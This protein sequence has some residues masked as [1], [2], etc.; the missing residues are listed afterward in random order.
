MASSSAAPMPA[1][2]HDFSPFFRVYEDG[3]VER[4]TIEE[5]IPASFDSCTG[6]T[7]KDISISADVPARL[8][9]PKIAAAASPNKLPL[10]V[11]FRGGG[12]CMMSLSTPILHN[13]LNAFAAASNVVLLHVNYRRAP[14]HR[15][16]VPYEDSWAAVEW[17]ASHRGGDGPEPW[18]ADHVDFDRVF[19]AG[20]SAG[21]NIAHNLA[22]R[23]AERELPGGVRLSGIVLVQPY[24]WGT[25]ST[26]SAEA[27]P[28]MTAKLD[29]LWPMLCPTSASG[30]DDPRV[31]PVAP[32]APSLAGLGCERVL[33]CAA[34]KDAMRDWA[35]IYYEA[36]RRSGWRGEAE[37]YE[38]A[39]EDHG[40]YLH[41]P[42]GENASLL[43]G[44]IA[45]FLS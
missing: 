40:F 25:E 38:S 6:V 5:Q 3:S 11:Y 14:E 45:A 31:N 7:S 30:N 35:R 29:R 22:M 18:L 42:D 32:G 39:G 20:E 34:E 19:L 28:E 8:Y 17:A 1:V 36:L 16:P 33:V 4:M 26:P 23:A 24:F 44:R 15:I 9:L 21:A 13:H 27:N 43:L 41:D 37:M 10:V 2:A 12:F